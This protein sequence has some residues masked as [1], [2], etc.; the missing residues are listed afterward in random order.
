MLRPSCR[1][2]ASP[3]LLRH[4]AG[5]YEM[6]IS[7]VVEDVCIIWVGTRGIHIKYIYI[8][9]YMYLIVVWRIV[10]FKKHMITCQYEQQMNVLR[11]WVK[12]L[13]QYVRCVIYLNNT[14]ISSRSSFHYLSAIQYPHSSLALLSCTSFSP[15]SPPS[16]SFLLI[17]LLLLLQ[18]NQDVCFSRLEKI[19]N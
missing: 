18:L 14:F 13:G 7:E 12:F 6:K 3:C 8:Y 17:I 11:C 5:S 1:P 19:V 15:P 10:F 2:P 9:V 4:Q 16:A